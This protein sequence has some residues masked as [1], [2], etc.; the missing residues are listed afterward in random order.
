MNVVAIIPAKGDSKRVPGKNLRMMLGKPLVAWAIEAAKKST[1]IDRVIVSTSDEEI[2][3]T[4]KKYGAEVPFM[5]PME[6]AAGGGNIEGALLHA[7]EWLKKNENYVPDAVVLLQTTNPLRRTE[8][9]D[10]AIKQFKQSGADST[11]AVCEALGNHNPTWMLMRDEKHGARMF[12]GADIRSISSMRS[13]ELPK[14]YFRNDI[15]Y[16][17]KASNLYQTPPNHYGDKVDLLVM[18]EIFDTDIN[19]PEDWH[20]TEDKLRRLVEAK[21]VSTP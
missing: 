14:C 12:N 21:K 4:A 10:T 20:M 6:I 2:A 5:E 17:F 3:E 13:Q 19:T 7:I 18:D 8:D 15:A 16:V 11:V 9:I 1:Y